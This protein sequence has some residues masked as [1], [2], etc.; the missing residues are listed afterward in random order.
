MEYD[1]KST[2]RMVSTSQKWESYMYINGERV[3]AGTFSSREDAEYAVRPLGDIVKLRSS[4]RRVDGLKTSRYQGVTWDKTMKRWK[5]AGRMKGRVVSLGY[6]KNELDA[7]RAYLDRER[8][9]E[10]MEVAKGVYFSDKR[11]AWVVRVRQED[12]LV[13]VGVYP[14][15][16][17]ALAAKKEAMDKLGR[18]D[19]AVPKKR[20]GISWNTKTGRWVVHVRWGSQRAYIGKYENRNEAESA[21]DNGLWCLRNGVAIEKRKPVSRKREAGV[22]WEEKYQR[23]RAANYFYGKFVIFGYS[24]LKEK[25]TDIYE[26]GMK[27]GYIPKEGPK[28]GRLMPLSKKGPG[29]KWSRVKQA[30]RARG[31]VNGKWTTFGYFEDEQDAV[32]VYQREMNLNGR[33]L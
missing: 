15:Q 5:A 31:L 18:G 13:T 32:D 24:L 3:R 26:R 23:Y 30:W 20:V 14:S 10:Q 19:L 12:A 9:S 28:A 22:V 2:V 1:R 7:L 33:D 16:E 29:V 6:Y 21:Y 4:G 27:A 25:A 8:I 11:Q 17:E